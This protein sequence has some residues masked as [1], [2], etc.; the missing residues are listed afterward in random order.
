VVIATNSP[1]TDVV[2]T[3]TKQFPYR[4]YALAAAIP[5]GVVGSALY[6]DT[7][8]PYHYIRTLGDNLLIIGGEDHKTGHEKNPENRFRRLERWA[9]KRFPIEEVRYRWSGQVFETLDGLAYIGPDPS[10][11]ANV[12]IVTGDS[13]MGITHGTIAGMLIS[14]LIGGVENPWREVYDPARKPIAGI[15]EFVTENIDVAAQYADWVTPGDV[16]SAQGVKPGN[17]AIV[18]D[19]AS[20]LAV[21]RTDGGEIHAVSAVCTHLGCVVQWNRF[22]KS[23]DCPCH[24]SRFDRF[25]KTL[26]GP[27]TRD[28]AAVDL[29]KTA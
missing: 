5:P 24:G 25:G 18:R 26:N 2:A 12:Y 13:G 3:H 9:R 6:W 8:D 11:L 19:G 21:Y 16:S 15:R 10:G 14:D 28:L 7:M 29:R 23:W 27:A 20:K 17:G 4:T 1:I 22:E